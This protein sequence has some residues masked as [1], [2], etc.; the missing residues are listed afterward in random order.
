L[1]KIPIS[2]EHLISAFGLPEISADGAA[3]IDAWLDGVPDDERPEKLKPAAVLMPLID[4]PDG[5][6]VLLTQ[7]TAHLSAHAGQISFPGGRFEAGDGTPENT[8]LRETEEE[9]GLAR[10]HI[11]VL[12]RLAARET[13]TGYHVVPVVGVITPPFPVTPD[14]GEVAEVFE[15][16]L[17]FVL[18]PANHRFETRIMSG[19]Q[20][21]FYSVPYGD[22]YIWGLTARLL[23]NLSQ[24][25]AR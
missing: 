13:G 21:Q 11:E 19:V 18:D 24:R 25:L 3:D 17:S 23:V 6:T 4:H 20:R 2:R 7:R 14:P 5:M 8:A 16:P 12:G 15:V 9:I 22:Y 1:V 10:A